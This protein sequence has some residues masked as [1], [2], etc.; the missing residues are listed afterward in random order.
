MM[1]FENCQ[2]FE[3]LVID[4]EIIGMAKHIIGGIEVRDDPIGLDLIREMGHNAEYFSH[5]H[6]YQWFR[7]EDY[8]PSMVIDRREPEDWERSGALTTWDRAKARVS[9]LLQ[10]YKPSPIAD[11]LR[12]ELRAITTRAAKNIGMDELPPL[13]RD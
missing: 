13:P 7:K 12:V 8:I 10:T 9:Q 2:S 5:D 4:A 1:A 3:K 6:T 11:E